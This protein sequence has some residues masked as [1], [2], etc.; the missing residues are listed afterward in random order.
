MPERYIDMKRLPLQAIDPTTALFEVPPLLKAYLR[1]GGFIGEGAVIDEQFRTTDVCIIVKTDLVTEKYAKHYALG[2][3]AP[4]P[5]SG[6][7][8]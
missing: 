3:E 1:F 7:D 8:E 6:L 5:A 4:E 2:R